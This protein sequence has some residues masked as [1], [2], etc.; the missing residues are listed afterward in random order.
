MVLTTRL[1][2]FASSTSSGKELLFSLLSSHESLYTKVPVKNVTLPGYDGYFTVTAGHSPMLSTLK[3]GV[4]SFSLKDSNEVVKYF[5]SSGF[6]VYKQLVFYLNN[7]Y[8]SDESHTADVMGVEVVPLDQLD[9]DRATSVLQEVL[10]ETQGD[11]SQ[12]AKVKT[13]LTQDL[14]SSVIKALQ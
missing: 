1:L 9:K 11:T 12:W 2:R 6:F 7:F 10:A 14:C 3:P 13:F 4:I 8:R 5:I